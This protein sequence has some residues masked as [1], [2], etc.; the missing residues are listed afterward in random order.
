[1]A[2]KL[3]NSL[4]FGFGRLDNLPLEKNT[5]FDSYEAALNYATTDT[6]AYAGQS[7]AVVDVEE[8]TTTRYTIQQDKTLKKDGGEI[9]WQAI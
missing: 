5:L 4:P 8:G 7:I 6:T 2:D 9:E 1:M 3:Y